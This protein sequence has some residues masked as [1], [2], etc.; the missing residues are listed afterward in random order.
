MVGIRGVIFSVVQS[1]RAVG[2]RGRKSSP[3][4]LYEARAPNRFTR[5]STGPVREQIDRHGSVDHIYGVEVR[6]KKSKVH[7]Y[8]YV[9]VERE[10]DGVCDDGVL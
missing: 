6:S 8:A 2:I 4:I 5:R 3:R 7:D 10:G 9:V 1:V